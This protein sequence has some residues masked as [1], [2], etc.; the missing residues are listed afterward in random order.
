[1]SA[2]ICD[3][4]EIETRAF[5]HID[6]LEGMPVFEREPRGEDERTVDLDSPEALEKAQGIFLTELATAEEK[7]NGGYVGLGYFVTKWRSSQLDPN[8]DV[9]RRLV[10]ELVEGGKL[11][12]YEAPDGAQA[13]RLLA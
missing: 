10:D 8:P 3:G 4:E 7:F 13:I 12:I 6:L 5:D 9:R 1:M 11:E 2:V